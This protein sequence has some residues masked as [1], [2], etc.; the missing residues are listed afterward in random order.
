MTGTKATALDDFCRR[1]GRAYT[2]FDYLGHGASSGKFTEGTIGRWLVDALAVLD[3][4][5]AGPQIIVGSSMGGWIAA[6][7]ALARPDRVAGLVTLAA[8]PDFTARLIEA[9]LT[10]EDRAMLARDGKIV[11]P[12]DYDPEGYEITKDLIDEG[13]EHLILG[14]PQ[15]I[16]CPVRMIHGDH[17]TDVP[18]ALSAELL[19]A[20]ESADATMTLV[21]G[22]D[23]RLSS[24]ADIA[25][26][27]AAIA[28]LA[29]A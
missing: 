8:A 1:E 16:R 4:V 19:D 28:E 17:D 23:H 2:R 26:M 15:P 29:G 24:P 11:D 5:T 22:A 10:A 21:K 9:R 12:S 13:R 20:V 18:W 3:R 27:E 6:L 14:R 25:R 7:L